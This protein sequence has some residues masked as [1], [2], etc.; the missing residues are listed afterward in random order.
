M[1]SHSGGVVKQRHGSVIKNALFGDFKRMA[2]KGSGRALERAS[3]VSLGRD[4]LAQLDPFFLAT[5]DGR[6]KTWRLLGFLA[7]AMGLIITSDLVKQTWLT[8]TDL[9]H[10]LDESN[11]DSAPPLLW[12]AFGAAVLAIFTMWCV[13]YVCFQKKRIEMQRPAFER[14]VAYFFMVASLCFNVAELV[15]GYLSIS[16][17]AILFMLFFMFSFGRLSPRRSMQLSLLIVVVYGVTALPFSGISHNKF[18]SSRRLKLCFPMFFYVCV[19]ALPYYFVGKLHERSLKLTKELATVSTQLKKQQSESKQILLNILP[20]EIVT[21]FM[22]ASHGEIADTFPQ[23]S[24]V[25]AHVVG[26]NKVF[27]ARSTVESVSILNALVCQF[28]DLLHGFQCSKVK[29]IGDTYMLVSGLPSPN[30]KR[31]AQNAALVA[32]AFV[33]QLAVFALKRQFEL[34]F[35]IG[36][37]SGTAVA[38][39]IGTSRFSYDIWGDTVNM[40]SRMY[41][42]CVKGKIQVT[43]ATRE[44]LE[45]EFQLVERGVIEVKGKGPTKTFFLEGLK[46]AFVEAEER[47]GGDNAVVRELV[48]SGSDILREGGLGGA[49][50]AAAADDAA[51]GGEHATRNRL[52]SIDAGDADMMSALEG[53]EDRDRAAPSWLSRQQVRMFRHPHRIALHK[54]ARKLSKIRR[55]VCGT[56]PSSSSGSGAGAAGSSADSSS[57]SSWATSPTAEKGFWPGQKEPAGGQPAGG[58]RVSRTTGMAAASG[59]KLSRGRESKSGSKGQ[60]NSRSP[61]PNK[62]TSLKEDASMLL[63]RISNAAVGD[64]HRGSESSIGDQFLHNPTYKHAGSKAPSMAPLSTGADSA[65]SGASAQVPRELTSPVPESGGEARKPEEDASLLQNLSQ[66]PVLVWL[67]KQF[68]KQRKTSTQSFLQL[69]W[70]LM[71]LVLS[72]A[73]KYV[74]QNYPCTMQN[75]TSLLSSAMHETPPKYYYTPEELLANMS[76]IKCHQYKESFVLPE[77]AR[78]GSAVVSYWLIPSVLL[79]VLVTTNDTVGVR[80]NLTGVTFTFLLLI[81]CAFVTLATFS[82]RVYAYFL[83]AYIFTIR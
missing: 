12:Y 27:L 6:E 80:N 9:S 2:R 34:S 43:S 75:P 15:S 59:R 52:T 17:S 82:I 76:S 31:H 22:D 38:G 83:L 68:T 65:R 66:E 61:V 48:Q 45:D 56:Q 25:F 72:G 39:V 77:H 60:R 33:R 79:Y 55:L 14:T 81:G 18:S 46:P 74:E 7:P 3:D 10:F 53:A 67:E 32:L 40:A 41:S 63:R 11:T 35:K 28:D 26:L 19:I 20:K 70:L 8:T 64:E 42:H 1:S 16:D 50:A 24:I 23:C 37:A 73:F 5:K 29:T 44:L 69:Y 51:S 30:P 47:V 36:I 57:S 71:L 21:R 49:A 54:W 13:G 4:D 78:F 62:R 58:Q